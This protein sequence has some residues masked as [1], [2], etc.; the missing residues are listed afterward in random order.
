MAIG[1]PEGGVALSLL[2]RSLM[3]PTPHAISKDRLELLGFRN[4]TE[5]YSDGER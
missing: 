1:D 3:S 2:C 5:K 4:P